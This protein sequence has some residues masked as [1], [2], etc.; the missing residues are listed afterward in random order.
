MVEVAGA[1]EASWS[2][3]SEVVF[4]AGPT[5]LRGKTLMRGQIVPINQYWASLYSLIGCI[6]DC[7]DKTFSFPTAEG[8]LTKL[9]K[10][11]GIEGELHALMTIDGTYASGRPADVYPGQVYFTAAGSGFLGNRLREN[12][13]TE[14]PL[15]GLV[16]EGVVAFQTP[17]N[18]GVPKNPTIGELRLFPTGSPL[19]AG[20]IPA[21]GR[22]VDAASDLGTLLTEYGYSASSGKVAVPSMKPLPPFSWAIASSGMF[23][24]LG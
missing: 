7:T 18:W 3:L 17:K 23:P 11:P 2:D 24:R 14:V 5:G 4:Q 21:D 16:E 22:T 15:G 1:A 19:P 13:F 8:P 10:T 20:F 6:Y 9:S 12:G